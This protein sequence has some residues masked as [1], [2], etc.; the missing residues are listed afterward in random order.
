MILANTANPKFFKDW[1][2]R[3][4]SWIAMLY[5]IPLIGPINGEISMA[6][7]ITAVELV[8]SPTDAII[9]A[10]TNIQMLVPLKEIPC[11]MELWISSKSSVCF[12]KLT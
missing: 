2:S 12:C 6:P 3:P 5:P 10:Q 11:V 9:I 4:K 1:R 7:I 8:L